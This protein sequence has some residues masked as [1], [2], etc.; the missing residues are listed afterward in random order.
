[1]LTNVSAHTAD[2]RPQTNNPRPLIST[3]T[4]SIAMDDAENNAKP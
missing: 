3:G 1:V 2:S 4:S